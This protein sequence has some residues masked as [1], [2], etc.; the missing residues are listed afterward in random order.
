MNIRRFCPVHGHPDD[1]LTAW[2]CPVAIETDPP[3]K[4]TCPYLEKELARRVVEVT[5]E[6]NYFQL[7]PNSAGHIDMRMV[8]EYRG[9][10][11]YGP[12]KPL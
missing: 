9:H 1:E 8:Q 7:L 11:K 6:G 3:E 12:P 5:E 10:E 2:P 4:K